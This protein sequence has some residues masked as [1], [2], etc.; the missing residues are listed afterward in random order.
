VQSFYIKNLFKSCGHTQEKAT[1]PSAEVF[2]NQPVTTF[3][4][5]FVLKMLKSKYAGSSAKLLKI[6]FKLGQYTRKE[7]IFKY[8]FNFLKSLVA[9]L[10]FIS[11]QIPTML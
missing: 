11:S 7:N 9:M 8:K 3:L 10:K 5:L 6:F 2:L 1:T 4:F